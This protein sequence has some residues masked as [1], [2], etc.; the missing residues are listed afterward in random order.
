VVATRAA[1]IEQIEIADRFV[2]GDE[3]GAEGLCV[4]LAGGVDLAG[5]ADGQ[6]VVAGGDV[7]VAGGDEPSEARPFSALGHVG[8][9]LFQ[10]GFDPGEAR[11]DRRAPAGFFLGRRGEEMAEGVELDVQD[12]G[13]E[14]G[15]GRGGG[16]ATLRE[17]DGVVGDAGETPERE[18]GDGEDDDDEGR[19]ADGETLGDG[20]LRHGKMGSAYS[21]GVP[22]PD[23]SHVRHFLRWLRISTTRAGMGARRTPAS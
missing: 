6:D 19:E 14:V 11:A 20:E 1:F 21:F 13:L 9:E 8:F 7:K 17:V 18:C 3:G 23:F 16:E 15:D 10:A 12:V 2:V 22:N 4:G 5:V